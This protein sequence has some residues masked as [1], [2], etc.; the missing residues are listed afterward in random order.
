SDYEFSIDTSSIANPK[1]WHPD[2]PSLYSA[3]SRVLAGTTVLDERQTRFGVRSIEFRKTDGKFYI[4]N[5]PLKLFGLDRH[6]QYP[7]VGRAARNRLQGK[8]ADIVKYDIGINIVRTSHYPQDP[9]FLDRCDEVGLLVLEEIPGWQHIGD[10]AW[11][12]V[13]VTNVKEMVLRDR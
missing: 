2:T 8:D 13:S 9:E 1:R 3:R 6:E 11:K 12:A 4:N 10:D 7:F 5:Q